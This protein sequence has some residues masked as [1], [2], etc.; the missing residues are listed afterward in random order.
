MAS[1]LTR[2]LATTSLVSAAKPT[3]KAPGRARG[4]LGQDVGIG[5]EVEREVALALDLLLGRTPDAVVGHRGGLD[6]DAWRVAAWCSTASR[7]SSA[8]CTGT[9]VAVAGGVS[10]VGP[11]TER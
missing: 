2:A 4:H 8:V 3:M 11:E 7:I 5:R 6:D 10:A 9:N 1:S